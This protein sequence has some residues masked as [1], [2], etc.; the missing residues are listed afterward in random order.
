MRKRKIQ[1]AIISS[2]AVLVDFLADLLGPHCEVVLHVIEEGEPY[3]Q[4]IRNSHISGRKKGKNSDV[5][6]TRL[7]AKSRDIDYIVNNYENAPTGLEIKTNTYFI[8]TPRGELIGM[9]CINFDLSLPLM[10]QNWLK[11][12]LGE[13]ATASP[14]S[15]P[16]AESKGLPGQEAPAKTDMFKSLSKDIIQEVIREQD[17]PV[18]RMTPE[19]RIQILR[20]LK[21]RGVFRIKY[22]VR[23]VAQSLNISEPSVYRYLKE[24]KTEE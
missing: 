4:K 19:E 7:P 8:H 21:S 13:M 17:A 6:G 9:L 15:A 20:V 22:A 23:E 5:V 1:K 11:G 3:I 12:F 16:C 2:Y 14:G 10:A 24:L 18:E